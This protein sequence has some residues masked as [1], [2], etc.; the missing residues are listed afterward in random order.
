MNAPLLKVRTVHG[1]VRYISAV[2]FHNP[3]RTQLPIY[4]STG[5]PKS[6]HNSAMGWSN[7]AIPTTIHRGNI[8][9]VIK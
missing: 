2:D 5:K 4:T 6:Y 1:A 8:A 3:T 9:E 7:S